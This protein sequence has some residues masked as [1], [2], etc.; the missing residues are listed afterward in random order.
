MP[1]KK[2]KQKGSPL[3]DGDTSGNLG[4]PPDDPGPAQEPQLC[5]KSTPSWPMWSHHHENDDNTSNVQLALDEEPKSFRIEPEGHENGQDD[6]TDSD[7]TMSRMSKASHSMAPAK[8][9]TKS[10]VTR[11][12]EPQL[13]MNSSDIDRIVMAISSLNFNFLFWNYH[14]WIFYF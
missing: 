6:P 3:R 11:I 9:C 5:C 1:P 10:Y 14:F 4:K 12:P 7:S 13:R 2:K 8:Q